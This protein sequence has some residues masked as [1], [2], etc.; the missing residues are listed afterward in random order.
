MHSGR[1]GKEKKKEIVPEKI[2]SPPPS[3]LFVIFVI[4]LI[5]QEIFHV[6]FA[7][8]FF[9][10]RIQ[11]RKKKNLKSR[12]LIK[13]LVYTCIISTVSVR[14]SAP[15]MSSFIR[16]DLIYNSNL[17]ADAFGE[18]ENERLY[19]PLKP[20]DISHRVVVFFLLSNEPNKKK[21]K[22]TNWHLCCGFFAGSGRSIPE[23]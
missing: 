10:S 23:L 7:S 4:F 21:V 22:K 14:N 16:H 20:H 13:S 11:E 6:T 18:L 12:I 1:R 2:I 8:N 9:Q 17:K 3:Y 5:V 19:K 15:V